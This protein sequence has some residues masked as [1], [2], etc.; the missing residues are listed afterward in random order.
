MIKFDFS[1]ELESPETSISYID[2][3]ADIDKDE[4]KDETVNIDENKESNIEL[5]VNE[6]EKLNDN[7]DV[8]FENELEEN[9]KID[10]D[11]IEDDINNE[12]YRH[13]MMKNFLGNISKLT[14]MTVAKENNLSIEEFN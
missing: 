13:K 2:I 7:E 5:T 8:V 9:T 12:E 10:Y 11:S 4:D 1:K 6:N 14:A 3:D